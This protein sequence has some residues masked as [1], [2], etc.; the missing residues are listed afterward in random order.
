MTN[1][2]QVNMFVAFLELVQNPEKYKEMLKEM[3]ASS[4]ELK[5]YTEAY[6]DVKSAN[7]Y[8]DKLKVTYN[9]QVDEFNAKVAAF[10]K[11]KAGVLKAEERREEALTKRQKDLDKRSIVLA[12]QTLSLE[13]KDTALKK[14]SEQLR[15]DQE[16]VTKL[17]EEM[18]I[19]LKALAEKEAKLKAVLGS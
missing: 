19:R 6:T 9:A 8:F 12:D 11:Q 14:W 7:K 13:E 15:K 2:D 17:E 1:I 16:A 18:K 4:N 5:E 3:Q 10:E